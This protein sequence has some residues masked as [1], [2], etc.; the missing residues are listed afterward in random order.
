MFVSQVTCVHDFKEK[1]TALLL[2][3]LSFNTIIF[4]QWRSSTP[5]AGTL[6]DIVF[7]DRQTGYA[8]GQATGVGSCTSTASILKTMD[9][10]KTGHA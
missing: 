5:Y 7:V 4:A 10:G 1:I 2:F 9:A 3:I 6:Q 8:C